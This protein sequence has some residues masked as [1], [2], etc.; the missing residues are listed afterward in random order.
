MLGCLHPCIK[1]AVEARDSATRELLDSTHRLNS[2]ATVLLRATHVQL[3]A[4]IGNVHTCTELAV[5]ASR[6]AMQ[7][8]HTANATVLQRLASHSTA[9]LRLFSE[10]T[11][12]M[13]GN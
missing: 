4:A 3:P 6:H 10:F 8:W 5:A 11:R 2:A 7:K 12:F 13:D 1:E 9:D